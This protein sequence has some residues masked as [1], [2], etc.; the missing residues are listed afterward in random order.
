MVSISILSL[1]LFVEFVNIESI[2]QEQS[3]LQGVSLGLYR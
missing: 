2:K 3:K 1:V